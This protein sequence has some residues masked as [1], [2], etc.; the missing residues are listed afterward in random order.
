[1]ENCVG[2]GGNKGDGEDKL[3]LVDDDDN[4]GLSIAEY[5]KDQKCS[6]DCPIGMKAPVNDFEESSLAPTVM[7]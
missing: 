1:M 2:V 3:S 6:T 7:S 5:L 4:H